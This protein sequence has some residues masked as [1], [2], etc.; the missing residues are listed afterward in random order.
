M[1]KANGKAQGA[2]KQNVKNS[3]NGQN[4]A[5]NCSGKQNPENCDR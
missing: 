1:K 2:G 4:N 3:Q 5:K